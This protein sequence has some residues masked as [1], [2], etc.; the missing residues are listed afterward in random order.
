MASVTAVDTAALPAVKGRA[1]LAGVV[2]SEF[3]KIRSVRS[4]YWTLFALLVV[5]IGVGA[6]VTGLTAGHWNQMS[7]GDR[8]TFDPTQD[9]LV[10]LGFLGQLII[11]VLGAMVIT[12]EYSTGM[13][14]T[15]LTVMPRRPTVFAAKAL[16]LG[17]VT[18]VVTL[19]TS[20]VVF[21]LGQALVS[22]THHAASLSGPHVLSAVIGIALYVTFCGLLG[23]AAGAI[24]RQTAGAITAVIGLLFVLPIIVNFLPNSIENA[25]QRWLPSS[26]GNSI[27]TTVGSPG[28]HLFSAWG[29]M[30]VLGAYV[31]IL[32]CVGG[33]LFRKRD[34]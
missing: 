34:A 26:A 1:G 25:M 8:A 14:R 7:A 12:A 31:V 13:I 21:F 3:T 6:L 10:G 29:E 24:L 2:R 27:S 15:S 20:F 17:G 5:G 16:V 4:T 18:L 9:S 28:A 33:F 30:A 11:V 22:S 19:V 32:L 23:F